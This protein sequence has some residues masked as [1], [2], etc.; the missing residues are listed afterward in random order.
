MA[1]CVSDSE[2]VD[3]FPDTDQRVAFCASRWEQDKK[4][5]EDRN[6]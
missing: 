2:S 6:S 1:R 4:E 3:T 5:N